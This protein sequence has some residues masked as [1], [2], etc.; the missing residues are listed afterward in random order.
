MENKNLNKNLQIPKIDKKIYKLALTKPNT[1][2]AA[3]YASNYNKEDVI[4]DVLRNGNVDV[5]IKRKLNIV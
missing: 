5:Y 3:N 2:S 4:F 1:N